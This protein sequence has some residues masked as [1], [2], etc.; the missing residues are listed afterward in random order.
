MSVPKRICKN[1]KKAKPETVEHYAIHR[2]LKTG[3]KSF[4]PT[5]RECRRTLDR[6][7]DA[8]ANAAGVLASK[9]DRVFSASSKVCALCA[10]QPWRVVGPRCRG[11]KR[12]YQDEKKVELTFHRTFERAV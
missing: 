1:C 5:C 11:C 7:L 12:L 9:V 8:R 2:R 3:S 6:E 10:N 4:K